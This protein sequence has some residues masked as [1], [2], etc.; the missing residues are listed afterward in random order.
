MKSERRI[1]PL[2]DRHSWETALAGV[3]HAYAHTWENCHAMWLTTAAPTF[4]YSWRAAEG[5]AVCALSERSFQGHTDIYTPYGFGGFVG[6]G[7]WSGLRDDWRDFVTQAGYVCGFITVNPILPG[8]AA[9][10]HGDM[11]IYNDLFLLEL[12]LSEQAL[13]HRLSRNRRRQLERFVEPAVRLIDDRDRCAEFVL[14]HLRA[15]YS[16]KGAGAAYSFTHETIDLLTRSP[17]GLLLGAEADG[18]LHSV[19]LFL[20]TPHVA[21]SF[22]S[23]STPRGRA[24][25]AALLWRA[26]LRLRRLGI[27]FLNM[28][29]GVTRGDGI[30]QFKQRFGTEQLPL[31]ALKQV[32][33][34]ETY[35]AL[36]RSVGANP[37][38]YTAFFPAYHRQQRPRLEP[39]SSV[40]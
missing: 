20:Y 19:A 29:G 12:R 22:A 11:H 14:A 27:P 37:A 10:F 9:L 13:L 28:G 5:R 3:P 33:K 16:E 24:Y 17:S 15:F 7:H 23:V 2:A 32:Y 40:R 30:A 34:A 31:G 4:L 39:T 36:C 35:V 18:A 8:P 6:T 26:I 25:T 1:I 21:E 38:D